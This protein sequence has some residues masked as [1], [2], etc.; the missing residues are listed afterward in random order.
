MKP[1]PH[2]RITAKPIIHNKSY[3]RSLPSELPSLKLSPSSNCQKNRCYHSDYTSIHNTSTNSPQ[4]A[5]SNSNTGNLFQSNSLSNTSITAIRK[6]IIIPKSDID[7][8]VLNN[9]ISFDTRII[10]ENEHKIKNSKKFEP[11]RPNE[12]VQLF[13]EKC[14]EVSYNV[15]EKE[16]LEL[17]T[18]LFNQLITAFQYPTIIRKMNQ[19]CI[20]AVLSSFTNNIFLR[21][22]PEISSFPPCILFDRIENYY[23]VQW[24]VLEHSYC[25]L[26]NLLISSHVPVSLLQQSITHDFIIKLFR[27][28]AS[29]DSRERKYVKSLLYTIAGRVPEHGSDIL[30]CIKKSFVDAING[31]PIHWGLPQ[32]LD[33]FSR[34]IQSVP[35]YTSNSF[36]D[37]LEQNLLP[38][39]FSIDFIS[40]FGPITSLVKILIQRNTK[41]TN[42]V[43]MFL[44]N[45]FPI[46]TQ[47][48]QMAF[49]KEIAE[50]VK[51]Y[52]E[53]ITPLTSKS[54]FERIS[55]LYSDECAEI[56]EESLS[57]IYNDGF[58][59][60]LAQYFS[61]TVPLLLI[62]AKEVVDHYWCESV[63]FVALAAIQ[64]MSKIDLNQFK[65]ITNNLDFYHN[66]INSRD[67]EREAFWFSVGGYTKN[68]NLSSTDLSNKCENLNINNLI[69]NGNKKKNLSSHCLSHIGSP[70]S[71]KGNAGKIIVQQ[72]H[73]NCDQQKGSRSTSLSEYKGN[74]KKQQQ[75]ILSL[76][77]SN[78][79][80]S[81][82]RLSTG[83][84]SNFSQSSS[85]ASN[86]TPTGSPS[87]TTSVKTRKKKI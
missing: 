70:V 4:N 46:A 24:P 11:E 52:N 35:Q 69:E 39:H 38:L 61:S 81:L 73:E 53:F 45:H 42:L 37:V 12:F 43:I 86:H 34:I 21:A 28:F 67:K 54:L 72:V 47:K 78:S 84:K 1:Q 30:I 7:R 58:P 17:K 74:A 23:D 29:P 14:N 87:K 65:K 64:E 49:L 20:T 9:Q 2:S 85:I 75:K 10:I 27:C 22:L 31:E 15:Y 60:L 5:H 55:V 68:S 80:H 41:N 32:I 82:R 8:S 19:K 26:E 6:Q 48:K 56:A 59:Q 79:W 50:I 66:Q 57:M 83:T 62:R 51:L 18:L 63:T 71:S 77:E 3:H 25:L 44:L 13:I 16:N 40:F 76:N 33:L 36:D